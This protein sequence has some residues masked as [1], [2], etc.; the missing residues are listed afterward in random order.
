ML[1]VEFKG[2]IVAANAAWSRMLGWTS[3]DLARMSILDLLHPD[4][5]CEA[6]EAVKRLACDWSACSIDSRLR[7]RDGSYRWIAWPAVSDERYIHAVGR[8]VTTE[9]EAAEALKQ[10]E[11]ALR[12][13]QKME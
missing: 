4:D 2:A 11:E 6:R 10:A 9:R 5:L 13:S 7:H 1:V 12:Q 3:G 8:D